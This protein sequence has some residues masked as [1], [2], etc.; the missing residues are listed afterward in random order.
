MDRYNK[1]S[2]FIQ[3]QIF[4]FLNFKF[5]RCGKPHLRFTIYSKKMS[6]KKPI[7]FFSYYKSLMAVYWNT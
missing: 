7:L 5:L 3:M 2:W 4:V 1:K 6:L